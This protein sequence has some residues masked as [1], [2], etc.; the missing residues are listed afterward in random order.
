MS[1]VEG[2]GVVGCGGVVRVAVVRIPA[3]VWLCEEAVSEMIA[4]LGVCG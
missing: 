2:M 3:M 1:G 4:W